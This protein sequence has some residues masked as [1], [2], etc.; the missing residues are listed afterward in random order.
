MSNLELIIGIMSFVLTV[1]VFSYLLGDNFLFRFSMYLLVGI[2][3]GFSAALLITR[4]LV[5]YLI[6]PLAEGSLQTRLLSLIPLLLCVLL[7]LAVFPKISRVSSIPMAY[8]VGV[9][10]AL[11][12]GG[13]TL[14]TIVPQVMS[15]VE[16]FTPSLLYQGDRQPWVKILEAIIVAL[17]VVSS[18]CYFYWGMSKR[19]TSQNKRPALVEGLGRLGQVFIGVTLG[20]LFTGIYT[21]ALIALI[22]RVSSIADFFSRLAGH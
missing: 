20:A 17:G 7:A 11:T 19:S 18:L 12:I 14:G 2:T 3:A 6:I 21:S 4:V 1:I 10:T 5:P 22:S 13:I 15:T 9:A 8:I 16:R